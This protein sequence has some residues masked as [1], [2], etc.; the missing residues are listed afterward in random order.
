MI[1]KKIKQ[2]SVLLTGAGGAAVPDLITM[3]ESKR[4]RVL[5]AD[6]DKNAVGLY[7]ADKGLLLPAGESDEFL[8]ALKEICYKENVDAIIPLVDEELEKACELEKDGITVLLPKKNFISK[9]LDKYILMKELKKNGIAVPNTQLATDD[10]KNIQYPII[11][12]PRTGRGSR[13]VVYISSKEKLDAYITDYKGN[14]EDLLLQE[15]IDGT[16]YTVSVVV[17]RD[18][19]VQAVIPKEIIYKKGITRMAITRRNKK[20]DQLC[21][22]VQQCLR[23]DGPFN[24]QLRLNDKGDPYIFEINP[25]FSTSISLTIAAGIDE[26]NLLLEQALFGYKP[27]SRDDWKEG[28]V[29]LRHTTDKFIEEAD[30]LLRR[31]SI[32]EERK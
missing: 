15:Y 27:K 13:G 10:L 22:V 2:K 6:M 11:V 19:E 32:M 26:I 21:R 30:Y 14:L 5:T 7:V 18:S 12:K 8:P 28:I 17:W 4:Y 16:E 1:D 25:R 24:V 23:A 29:L 20:I 9:C 3:L 31:K